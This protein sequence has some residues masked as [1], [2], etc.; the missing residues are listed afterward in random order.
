MQVTVYSRENLLNPLERQEIP[1]FNGSVADLL[2]QNCSRY[3]KDIRP[4]VT[5]Y[6]D[7][8]RVEYD[9]WENF[10]LDGISDLKFVIEPGGLGATAIAAII[11]AVVA[12][13]S[14]VYSFIM[15]NRL[16]SVNTG[17][18]Q[19]G[20]TIYDVNAQGN[21]VKL[22]QI[23]PENFGYFK[24]YPDYLC[25]VHS[26]YRNNKYFIDLVLC[27][28]RGYYEHSGSYD[29]IYIAE[30]PLSSFNDGT[31]Q[32]RV[33]DPGTV[34]T[35]ENSIEDG[36]W[37]GWYSSIEV[38]SQGKTLEG[39]VE[40]ASSDSG[41]ATYSTT[42]GD[43]C[44]TCY[45]TTYQYIGPSGSSGMGS[46]NIP[47]RKEYPLPWEVGAFF[48]LSGASHV[49]AIGTENPELTTVIGANTVTLNLLKTDNLT[50][51]TWLRARVEESGVIVS[52]GDTIRVTYQ[53]S[54]VVVYWSRPSGTQGPRQETAEA[55]NTEEFDAEVLEVSL[56]DNELTIVISSSEAVIPTYPAYPTPA[57]T[58]IIS[59]SQV[60]KISA[61][62]PLPADYPNDG[63]NGMYRIDSKDGATT[64]VTRC[65]SSYGEDTTWEGFWSQGFSSND[66]SFVL[67][68]ASSSSAGQWVGPYRACPV[69]ATAS[70]F[71][72]DIKFPSGLGTLTNSGGINS[73]TVKIEIQYRTAGSSGSW[74]SLEQEWTNNTNDELAYTIVFDTETAG[75]YEFR[76]KNLSENDESMQALQTVKWVGLKSCITTQNKYDDMTVIICRFRGSE[77]LSELSQNQLWTL[78]TRKLPPITC[79]DANLNNPEYMVATRDIAPV[80]KYI[81]DNSKYKGIVDNVSLAAFDQYWQSKGMKLDG[82]LDDDNTLLE[83]LRDVLKAGM[84]GLTV[85]E[86]K[87]SFT[88]MHKQGN[89]EPLTQIFTPQN[90]TASPKATVTL[91]RDDSVNEVVVE[92]ID[93]ATYKT[94]TRYVHLN[95]DGEGVMTLYPT[96]NNQETLNAFG[97]TQE[98]IAVAM[99]LRRLRYLTYTNTKYEVKTELDG[100][101]CQYNDL[102]GLVLDHNLSNIT[103]RVLGVNSSDVIEVDREIKTSRSSGV[104][105]IRKLDGSMWQT[106]YQRQ[107]SRH[108]QLSESLPFTWNAEYGTSLEYPFFA[109]GELVKCWVTNVKPNNKSCT[110][111]LVNYD[112]RVFDDDPE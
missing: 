13:A 111:E 85:S 24:K 18:T 97:V 2:Q 22:Q 44:L 65:T 70:K 79:A 59:Q 9:D 52:A 94:A 75:N 38:T 107:D 106:E 87:L 14:V 53:R 7:N 58:S 91:R 15:A 29:D 46:S 19:T 105:Y 26:F 92:Y 76:I 28:G 50:N 69:G 61:Y 82:T 63:D 57:A 103:G 71:E 48:H 83:A 6:A 112:E 55:V 86:N 90:V 10:N 11:A 62:E 96:S 73:R 49:R 101:N 110:L 95:S 41:S 1:V 56:V 93:P 20:S 77:T 47:V 66:V 84:A 34:I 74:T 8:I 88:R 78:W 4:Y 81:C 5:A 51:L 68:D 42:F 37:W 109:I 12:V 21:K 30:S 33:Y 3:S 25:D 60:E 100:L 16:G 80:V 98:N 67:D 108:L 43:N 31:V 45:K 72:V 89:G 32:V 23:I 27:Q 104:I 39:M 36:C 102:V 35:A 64:Y 17:N 40:E 54:A 99:G